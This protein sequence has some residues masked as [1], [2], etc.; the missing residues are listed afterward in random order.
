MS[1][2]DDNT[3]YTFSPGLDATFKRL[4]NY[5]IKIFESFYKKQFK[6]SVDKYKLITTSRSQKEIQIDRLCKYIDFQQYHRNTC[7]KYP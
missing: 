4:K 3:T 7:C 6:S 5:T 2:A 1:Y